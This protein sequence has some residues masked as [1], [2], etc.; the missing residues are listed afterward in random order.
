MNF[1]ERQVGGSWINVYLPKVLD[2]EGTTFAVPDGMVLNSLILVY[3]M[4]IALTLTAEFYLLDESGK[5]SGEC[6]VRKKL[7]FVEGDANIL[8]IIDEMTG[9]TA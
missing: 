7:R 9:R 5:F 4:G 8:S 1:H 2:E 6:T 3:T